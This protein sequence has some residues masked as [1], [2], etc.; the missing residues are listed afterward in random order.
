MAVT[1][2]FTYTNYAALNPE[3]IDQARAIV[4]VLYRISLLVSECV[5]LKAGH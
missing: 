3:K 4:N 2:A 5:L 1:T